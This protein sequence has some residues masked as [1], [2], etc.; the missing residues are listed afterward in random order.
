MG[1]G[2]RIR[3]SIN[4]HGV[5]N[6]KKE[7]IEYCENRQDLKNREREIV[8]LNEISKKECMNISV[9]GLGGY[10]NENHEIKFREGQKKWIK[11]QW[12]DDGYREVKLKEISERTRG[13]W[14]NGEYR[15]KILKNINWSGKK[16]SEES[17][18][19]MS[20]SNTHQKGKNNSQY[21]TYWVTDGKVNKKIK[22]GTEIPQGWYKG[23]KVK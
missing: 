15:E 3:R 5:E 10:Q 16:H 2:R 18:K 11:S 7:I 14:K 20:E 8:D 17:K 12:E 9:G 4:K 19:K 1:S 22:K 13:L 6:H 21:G 23:R